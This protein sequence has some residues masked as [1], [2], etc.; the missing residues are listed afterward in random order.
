M[1]NEAPVR[2][3]ECPPLGEGGT[4]SIC[5]NAQSHCR[6]TRKAVCQNGLAVTYFLPPLRHQAP[7]LASTAEAIHLGSVAEGGP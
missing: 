2:V 5:G 3:A 1:T 6:S 4:P 7:P